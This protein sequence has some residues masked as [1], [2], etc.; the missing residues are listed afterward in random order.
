VAFDTPRVLLVEDHEDSRTM[1]AEALSFMGFRLV[2]AESAQDAFLRACDAHPDVIVT[3]VFLPG[4]DGLE[5]TRR[6]REDERTKSARIIVL[7]GRTVDLVRQQALDA[8]CDRF[9]LKPCLPE[10]LAVEIRDVLATCHAA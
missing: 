3:D 8:G 2:T 9:L 1:Y 4:T 6:L 10:A 5:L 7:T